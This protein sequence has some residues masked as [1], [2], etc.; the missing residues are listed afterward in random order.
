MNQAQ[1]PDFEAITKFIS[2]G[3]PLI[4]K[5]D[6]KKIEIQR[7]SAVDNTF[8]KVFSF[9]MIQG[10][11][12][13]ALKEPYS[14]VLTESQAKN[15]FGSEDPIDQVV[16]VN[17]RH[18]FKVTGVIADVPKNSH[19]Q[20]NGLISASS[21]PAMYGED[22]FSRW[23]DN[24]VPLYV[25]LDPDQSYQETNEKLRFFLKKYQG[26]NSENELYL[27]PLEQI[28]LYADVNFEFA[29][30]GSIK[31]IYIF[32]AISI[33]VL[34]IGCINFMNLET[35]RAADRARE[36]GLRKVVGAQKASLIKQFLGE[37]LLTVLFAM[38]LSLLLAAVLLNE[39]N[40]IVNRQLTLD[41]VNNW[42]FTAGLVMLAIF[43]GVLSGFY[44]AFVLSS[45]RPVQVLRGT[46][47]SGARNVLLRKF[48]IVFQ[49]SI[50]IG[51]II[52][53]IIILQQNYYLLNR[54]MGY[55]S[56]QMLALHAEG[57]FQK[58]ETLRTE[59]LKNPNI[60][61]ASMHDYM[62]H[63]SSNWCY[64]SWEGAG[65]DEYMKMNVNYID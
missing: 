8:L 33:F 42:M 2:W 24:W 22:V 5:P 52:G 10:D 62:P 12:N 30:V 56:D 25:M 4:T 15:V 1:S 37:S 19:L 54:D 53:T 61:I 45:F 64:I 50:S 36:V 65:P 32:A 58:V 38:V 43:V 60:K 28:H 26:E 44:P 13:T 31:N 51:L 39:F 34:L 48:L 35:A 16:R 3:D 55:S 23:G 17:N 14:L 7:V 9:P 29:V 49:F 41:L 18:D 6:N 59:L 40:Q 20:F 46:V 57:D 21:Y 27:R 63:S 47:S 11:V